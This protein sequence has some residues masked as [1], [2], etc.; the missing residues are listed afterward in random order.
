MK[1]ILIASLLI[2]PAFICKAQQQAR[3][4]KSAVPESVI[5]SYA[6]Q[7]SAGVNDTLWETETVT[8]YKVRHKE[9]GRESVWEYN[10]VGNWLRTYTIIG[11]EELP[12]LV[13]N[14]IQTMYPEYII[15]KAMIELSSN[16]KMYAVNL[17][18]GND[19]V[20][21]YFLMNG[22]LYR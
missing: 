9:D 12:L 10:S 2:A 11:T 21:E 8:I 6:S 3:I 13:L 4:K 19:Q 1:K 22:K 18:R 7:N 14:Q 16:G 5:K 15:K 17:Q 20:T